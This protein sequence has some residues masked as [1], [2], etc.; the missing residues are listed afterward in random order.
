MKFLWENSQQAL[1][2]KVSGHGWSTY[3]GGYSG[4]LHGREVKTSFLLLRLGFNPRA[5][6][7]SGSV[8]I[9]TL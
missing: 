7:I 8:P 5:G 9:L 6:L 3:G 2:T 1:N 4:A